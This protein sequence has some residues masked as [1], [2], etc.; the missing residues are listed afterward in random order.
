[1]IERDEVVDRLR[2]EGVPLFREHE[3]IGNT[4]RYGFWE[5][6][7]EYEERV[8]RAKAAD[9]QIDVHPSI[10]MEDKIPN[11]VGSLNGVRVCV[12]CVQEPGIVLGNELS[13]TRV[14]PEHILAVTDTLSIARAGG[15]G[16]SLVGHHFPATVRNALPPRRQDICFPG[17]VQNAW[18]TFNFSVLGS[19]PS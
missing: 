16:V 6:N 17:L 15:G 9:V 14:R 3:V 10:M 8:E 11:C 18:N 5:D 4:N 19:V 7:W 12:E 1:M 2:H 13:R